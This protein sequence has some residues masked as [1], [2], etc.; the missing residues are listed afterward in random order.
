MLKELVH[1]GSAIPEGI[2][3]SQP[4][5]YTNNMF[6]YMS[7]IYIARYHLMPPQSHHWLCLQVF[8]GIYTMRECHLENKRHTWQYHK[9]FSQAYLYLSHY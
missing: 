7:Y 3:K 5:I 2:P 8:Q 4:Q 9:D 1:T 6:I